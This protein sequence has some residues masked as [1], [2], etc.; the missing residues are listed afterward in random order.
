MT[1]YGKNKG[2]TLKERATKTKKRKAAQL[3]LSAKMLGYSKVWIAQT[4]V[5]WYALIPRVPKRRY[6]QNHPARQELREP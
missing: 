5:H 6:R 2:P 3:S 1:A 4:D